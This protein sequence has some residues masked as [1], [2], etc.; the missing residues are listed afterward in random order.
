MTNISS[1]IHSQFLSDDPYSPL[2]NRILRINHVTWGDEKLNYLVKYY[3]KLREDSQD[4]Y[5]KLAT[6]LNPLDVTPLFRNEDGHHTVILIKGVIRPKPSNPIINLVLF[7]LTLLSVISMGTLFTYDGPFSGSL[8]D[9]AP[10]L[11]PALGRGLAFAAS[12]LGILLAHEFGHYLAARYHQTAVTLPYFIPFPFSPFG[13]MGAFIRMKEPPKN[14]RIL[15][16]IGL[17]GP[18][19]GLVVAVPVLLVG[20]YLSDLKPLP[21]NQ[22]LYIEGNSILYLLAKYLVHGQWLPQPLS[23][24]GLHPL[25][26]WIRYLFTGLPI[27]VGGVDVFLH[28]VA[29]AGWAGLLVTALNLIPAGQLDGGHLIFVLLGHRARFLLPFVLVVLIALGTVWPV[30]WLWAFLIFIMGRIYAEPLDLITPLDA[31]RKL[32]AIFGLIVFLLVFTPVPLRLIGM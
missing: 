14:K 31:S 2:V 1:E 7:I 11:L 9:I 3:G 28:P 15:L 25:V 6:S 26:F 17:A 29:F 30:W 19:A 22:G 4:A 18:L 12:L 20:L 24:E 21:E 13:T 27:P 5:N 10:Y 16:D 8:A 32:I 23:Y